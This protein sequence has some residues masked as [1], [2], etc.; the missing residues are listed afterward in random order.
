[1]LDVIFILF[2]KNDWNDE[3]FRKFTTFEKMQLKIIHCVLGKCL[4][5]LLYFIHCISYD[6]GCLDTCCC[7]VFNSWKKRYSTWIFHC[8]EQIMFQ[9]KIGWIYMKWIY[10]Q[11]MWLQRHF[12]SKITHKIWLI[13]YSLCNK[14]SLMYVHRK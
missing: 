4:S 3:F 13:W 6:S 14:C 11:I 1:M 7:I 2:H 10:L 12:K 5:R 8:T 9:N